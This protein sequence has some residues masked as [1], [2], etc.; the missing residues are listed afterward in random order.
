M[1]GG[2]R[3]VEKRE[4]GDRVDRAMRIVFGF[5]RKSP[6][7][8]FSGD[9]GVVAGGWPEM[10]RERGEGVRKM[11]GLKG[12]DLINLV[13]FSGGPQ[14]RSNGGLSGGGLGGCWWPV[15]VVAAVAAVEGEEVMMVTSGGGVVGDGGGVGVVVSV[16]WQR[17]AMEMI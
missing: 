10:G 7:K 5:G 16:G 12:S 13:M 6:P 14:D 15:M 4:C 11:M 8:N 17:V 3:R 1:E 9:G 2:G